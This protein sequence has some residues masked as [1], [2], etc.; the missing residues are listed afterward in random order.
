[1]LSLFFIK[2]IEQL[3]FTL[4]GFCL[5]ALENRHTLSIHNNMKGRM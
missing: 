3:T 1:M 2:I 5:K 4:K